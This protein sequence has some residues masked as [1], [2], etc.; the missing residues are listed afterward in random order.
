MWWFGIPS[1]PSDKTKIQANASQTQERNY[2]NLA[3]NSFHSK[4]KVC[5]HH[6][7]TMETSIICMAWRL[8]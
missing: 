3:S 6:L 7:K 1:S 2:S 8:T 4:K 5:K